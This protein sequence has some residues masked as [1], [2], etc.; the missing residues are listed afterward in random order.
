MPLKRPAAG[1]ESLRAGFFVLMQA[2]GETE[3]ES[4]KNTGKCIKAFCI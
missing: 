1:G 4:R 3:N 2:K